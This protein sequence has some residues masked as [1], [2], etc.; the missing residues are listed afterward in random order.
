MSSRTVMVATAFPASG[1]SMA[2]PREA[3]ALSA[4]NMASA[5]RRAVSR[6]PIDHLPVFIEATEAL[7]EGARRWR[8]RP[9]G[10][11]HYAVEMRIGL[12]MHA[13]VEIAA[14]LVGGRTMPACRQQLCWQPGIAQQHL[15]VLLDQQRSN[16]EGLL[17][18]NGTL[19]GQGLVDGPEPLHELGVASVNIVEVPAVA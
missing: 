16:D 17:F 9:I 4:A 18:R 14:K 11:L 19:S 7:P 8:Q 5:Q 2:I 15:A 12:G 3:D 13:A 10:S 6:S 1:I